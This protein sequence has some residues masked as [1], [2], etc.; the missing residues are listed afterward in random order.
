MTNEYLCTRGRGS[1]RAQT[2]GKEG[3]VHRD[4]SMVSSMSTTF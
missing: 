4:Y 3:D 2:R 1:L